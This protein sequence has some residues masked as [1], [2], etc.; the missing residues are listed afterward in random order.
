[1]SIN[2]LTMRIAH[3]LSKLDS[4]SNSISIWRKLKIGCNKTF[5]YRFVFDTLCSKV[6]W[7][8]T[9]LYLGSV[10]FSSYTPSLDYNWMILICIRFW[11][12]AIVYHELHPCGYMDLKVW[13]RFKL[14][15]RFCQRKKVQIG[16]QMKDYFKAKAKSDSIRYGLW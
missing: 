15:Y 9:F 6:K 16:K 10:Q 11:I 5:I 3:W 4:S 7:F 14:L 1:M 8:K 13:P 12:I 2:Y